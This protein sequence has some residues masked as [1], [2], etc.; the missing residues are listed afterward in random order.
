MGVVINVNVAI[1]SRSAPVPHLPCIPAFLTE[2]LFLQNFNV[3]WQAIDTDGDGKLDYSEFLRG[4]I[5]EMSESR[6]A[7]VRKVLNNKSWIFQHYLADMCYLTDIFLR[8][9]IC[10]LM[11]KTPQRKCI[12]MKK[13]FLSPEMK[14]KGVWEGS[15]PPNLE[16]NL[17]FCGA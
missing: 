16:E 2:A 6:K 14:L 15:N 10:F 8:N 17:P 4:V 1:F 13:H 7:L 12:F 5:G 11:R 3:I 9:Q